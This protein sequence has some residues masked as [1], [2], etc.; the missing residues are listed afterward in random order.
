MGTFIATFEP[1]NNKNGKFTE[2]SEGNVPLIGN[3]LA[4]TALGTLIDHK[5]FYK[6]GRSTDHAY[7]CKNEAWV[8]DNGNTYQAVR[9]IKPVSDELVLK[10]ESL[11]S[12]AKVVLQEQTETVA[13]EA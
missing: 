11:L 13:A 8:A 2:D 10:A 9:I 7:M 12:P 5:Q 1:V 4:G 6:N 3:V